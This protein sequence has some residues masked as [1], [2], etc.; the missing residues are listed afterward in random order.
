MG[1]CRTRTRPSETSV[2]NPPLFGKR[3]SQQKETKIGRG[4]WRCSL[5]NGVALQHRDREA[6]ARRD[7]R[8]AQAADTRAD[9]HDVGGL[10][11]HP[12]RRRR[13]PA[14][15]AGRA[16]PA[17]DLSERTAS[18]HTPRH[19]VESNRCASLSI[20]GL[21]QSLPQPQVPE[22]I[23]SCDLDLRSE[24]E[25]QLCNSELGP[26]QAVVF[27]EFNGFGGRGVGMRGRRWPWRWGQP[28]PCHCSR[29]I[30]SCST[31]FSKKSHQA[32]TV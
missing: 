9:D 1:R 26:C 22:E 12:A 31:Q 13:G 27:T 25:G 23:E 8:A 3:E 32:T 21:S 15:R 16:P 7:G 30:S 19:R 18:H 5:T 4:R 24:L 28:S 20:P 17:R 10:G 14:G 2:H 29:G 6:V 11:H